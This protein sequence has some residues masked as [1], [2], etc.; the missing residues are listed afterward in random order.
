MTNIAFIDF[1]NAEDAKKAKFELHHNPGLGCDSLIVDFKKLPTTSNREG[2]Y[3]SR[4][5]ERDSG[6]QVNNV[7]NA[8]VSL[9]ILHVI[10][11]IIWSSSI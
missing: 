6:Y 2:K 10:M 9:P 3:S 4:E 8:N 1:A 5:R 11:S 7:M